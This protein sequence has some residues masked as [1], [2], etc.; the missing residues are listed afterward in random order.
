MPARRADL[1]VV[2]TAEAP[3]LPLVPVDWNGPS[4]PSPGHVSLRLVPAPAKSF[5]TVVRRIAM[6]CS[7]PGRPDRIL[8]EHPDG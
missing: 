5:P 2:P 8:R 6:P 4:C 3:S 1:A 7:A